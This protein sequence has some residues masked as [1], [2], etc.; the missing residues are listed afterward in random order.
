MNSRN[1][2]PRTGIRHLGIKD[3]N[4]LLNSVGELMFFRADE[5]TLTSPGSLS[6]DNSALMVPTP[7]INLRRLTIDSHCAGTGTTS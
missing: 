2:A 7:V 1:A 6:I 5:L 4:I 3:P